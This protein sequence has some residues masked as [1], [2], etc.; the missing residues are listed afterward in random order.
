M[1]RGKIRK[2]P[3][4]YPEKIR[5]IQVWWQKN[6]RDHTIPD[7]GGTCKTRD[8]SDF[9]VSSMKAGCKKNATQRIL[10]DTSTKKI[11]GF[12]GIS[13]NLCVDPVAG[14][15]KE[16]NKDNYCKQVSRPGAYSQRKYCQKNGQKNKTGHA[17]YDIKQSSVHT[18]LI[19]GLRLYAYLHSPRLACG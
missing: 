5:E 16:E 13:G 12:S 6:R 9:T 3:V 4:K 1:K 17:D 7:I 8:S 11:T 15:G 2:T 10:Q 19:G 14:K 18:T